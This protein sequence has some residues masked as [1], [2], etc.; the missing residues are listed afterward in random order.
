MTRH[1]QKLK[2]HYQENDDYQ[3]DATSP[4]FI[5]IIKIIIIA[6]VCD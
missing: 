2:H 1:S 5:D 6:C 3:E 4:T